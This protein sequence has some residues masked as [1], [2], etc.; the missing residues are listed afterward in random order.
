MTKNV[1]VEAVA[2]RSREEA[3]ASCCT[4]TV[5]VASAQRL[6]A[7]QAYRRAHVDK[8]LDRALQRPKS[9]GGG[10]EDVPDP[11]PSLTALVHDE[12]SWYVE[13]RAA[14]SKPLEIVAPRPTRKR[15]LGIRDTRSDAARW[16]GATV[17]WT[18]QQQ[19]V[20]GSF[21][22]PRTQRVNEMDNRST[23]ASV[24]LARCAGLGRGAEHTQP[25]WHSKAPRGP[26]IAS[27]DVIPP[28]RNCPFVESAAPEKS[29]TR[30]E[31]AG[32]RLLE[33]TVSEN[34]PTPPSLSPG[35]SLE[36]YVHVRSAAA[37]DLLKGSKWEGSR[38]KSA[39][40]LGVASWARH[41]GRILAYHRLVGTEKLAS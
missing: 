6:A 1:V 21:D 26:A 37:R 9:K 17:V 10:A 12:Y 29:D 25:V 40:L 14:I 31:L 11:P 23:S 32:A 30:V 18:W 41:S 13:P 5:P 27:V 19:P 7:I 34:A 24:A 3:S 36:E 38:E 16:A 2:V 15:Q 33:Q 35:E 22:I 20:G 39:E 4:A 28:A 8:A